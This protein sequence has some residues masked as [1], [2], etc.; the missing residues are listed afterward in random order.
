MRLITSII[1]FFA[2]GFATFA[3]AA[4]PAK[5]NYVDHI[6]P[7][8]REHCCACHN[9]GKAT[10]D[11]ALDSYDRIRK[12]GASGDAVVAGD[13]DGS[14]LFKLVSHKDQPYMPPN[15]E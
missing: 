15:S 6:Q 2:C 14:Y 7:I 12:G 1:A 4:G 8:L 13:V 9:Q 10:N 3:S 11:L 5:I